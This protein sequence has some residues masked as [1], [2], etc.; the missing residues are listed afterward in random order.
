M[1]TG[2]GHEPTAG[3]DLDGEAREG[4]HDV[5]G[6]PPFREVVDI[7][8]T[9]PPRSLV[10][11]QVE[12]ASSGRPTRAQ[13]AR[14]ERMTDDVLETTRYLGKRLRSWRGER[15][16]SGQDASERLGARLDR[17]VEWPELR[18]YETGAALPDTPAASHL[19]AM[20]DRMVGELVLPVRPV[21]PTA[22][23]PLPP[24]TPRPD[25]LAPLRRHL[26]ENH[27]DP[28]HAERF[29]ELGLSAASVREWARALEPKIAFEWITV[30]FGAQEAL[31]WIAA[32]HD[33]SDAVRLKAL[34]LW[35]GYE[36]EPET[37][38]LLE[39]GV[40]R[41]VLMARSQL[42]LSDRR[43]TQE[44]FRQ[45]WDLLAAIPWQVAGF[46][47]GEAHLWHDHGFDPLLAKSTSVAF[48]PGE[49]AAWRWTGMDSSIW[50]EWRR[51]GFEPLDAAS[52]SAAGLDTLIAV[53]WRTAGFGP[54]DA[55]VYRAV[56][57]EPAT[58][59]GALRV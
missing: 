10:I 50:D 7:Y 49:A 40:A 33:V 38:A 2:T 14:I 57:L 35:P 36:D 16:W 37:K 42:G 54:Q 5:D 22:S 25:D 27:R 52:W 18:L 19:A 6:A 45:G 13:W 28:Q 26:A 47:S 44:W 8:H 20:Y 17:A 58:A 31:R 21:G 34:G 51:S 56:D 39:V 15:N 4:A 59:K 3:T 46:D 12:H 30:R 11:H 23:V 1:R 43:A 41:E 55:V 48:D 53:S 32:G 9:D 29:F 24:R